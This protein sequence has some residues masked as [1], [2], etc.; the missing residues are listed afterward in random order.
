MMGY[1]KLIPVL[2][3]SLPD[4][5]GR[6]CLHQLGCIGATERP[7]H[8]L[9]VAVVEEGDLVGAERDGKARPHVVL[10]G[11]RKV[12]D[13]REPCLA[14]RLALG[15]A[16]VDR[17]LPSGQLPAGQLHAQLDPHLGLVSEG[18]E[19]AGVIGSHQAEEQGKVAVEGAVQETVG[20]PRHPRLLGEDEGRVAVRIN[21]PLDRRRLWVLHYLLQCQV[22][23]VEHTQGVNRTEFSI[24]PLKI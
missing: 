13:R 2:V 18:E 14:V 23:W 17:H 24:F 16:V 19:H 7:H 22:Y 5:D 8:G 12:G 1:L 6:P 15:V 21:A 11:Q 20:Q 9:A 4:H 10:G 3:A